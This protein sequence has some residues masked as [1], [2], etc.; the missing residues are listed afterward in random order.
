MG[1]EFGVAPPADAVR[2]RWV[3]R[4]GFVVNTAVMYVIVPIG[5]ELKERGFEGYDIGSVGARGFGEKDHAVPVLHV[6]IHFFAYAKHV[7]PA[8]SIN[9]EDIRS[10]VNDGAEKGP[11]FHICA[12]DEVS[13]ADPTKEYD[14]YVAKV[15]GDEMEGR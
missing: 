11:V 13:G 6:G 14:V 5:G 8:T 3:A 9:K 7:F 15:V 2:G 12:G 4:S 1:E 10:V